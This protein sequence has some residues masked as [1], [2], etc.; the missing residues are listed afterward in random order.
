MTMTRRE[1]VLLMATLG[2]VLFGVS[3]LVARPKVRDW[4][5]LRVARAEVR[6]QM[7]RDLDLIATRARWDEELARLSTQL[8]QFA[9]D[10]KMEVH[11]LSVMDGIAGKHGVKILQRQAGDEKRDGDV[12]E[13]PVECKDWAGGLEN[14]VR[15]LFELQAEGA[16]LDV[17]QLYVRP[18]K[19][20]DS[21]LRGRFSLSCIYTREST[22]QSVKDSASA[23]AD[24][25]KPK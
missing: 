23:V 5:D 2:A 24:P 9:A 13:V 22:G 10:A 4:R 12:Y 16:M 14:L 1:W 15:F 25:E 18:R 21:E 3:I 19:P 20:G 11:W 6:R 17:R 8:P 7:Q